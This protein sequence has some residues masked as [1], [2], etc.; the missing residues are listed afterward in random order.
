MGVRVSQWPAAQRA[1]LR[2][3]PVV[4][5]ELAGAATI[6]VINGLTDHEHP[7]Q[8]MADLLTVLEYKKNLRRLKLAYVGDGNNVAHSLMLACAKLGG[9]LFL[10]TPPGYR[11]EAPVTERCQALAVERGATIVWTADPA[12]AA[13][14]ADVVYTDAW[15]SMGQEEAAEVRRRIFSPPPRAP[16]GR[17][18]GRDHRFAQLGRLHAGGEPAARAKGDHVRAAA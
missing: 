14:G 3:M 9:T 18:D 5:R 15:A 6:P 10:G 12:E 2:H 17:S 8:A 1:G 4:V 7:C 11:P 13:R 16:G